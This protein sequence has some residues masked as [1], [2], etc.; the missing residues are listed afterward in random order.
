LCVWIK[1]QHSL[2]WAGSFELSGPT[3]D[4]KQNQHGPAQGL[5]Q[6]NSEH[7]QVRDA[8]ATLSPFSNI[9]LP[10]VQPFPPTISLEFP[11][12]QFMLLSSHPFTV[13][14]QVWLHLLHNL[15]LCGWRQQ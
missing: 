11:S 5:S 13:H 15:I 9:Q 6:P 2:S 1:S 4:A 7:L 12:L 8:T 14:L 10:P 3:S